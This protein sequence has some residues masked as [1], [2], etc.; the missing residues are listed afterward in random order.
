MI[1]K[2]LLTE[3]NVCVLV[4]ITTLH[5]FLNMSSNLSIFVNFTYKGNT[6]LIKRNL[7]FIN[8]VSHPI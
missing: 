3:T 5:Q 8:G 6:I 1:L 7:Q 4:L 2:K